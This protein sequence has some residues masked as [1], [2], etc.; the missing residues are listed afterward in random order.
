MSTI[1]LLRAPLLR[2][3]DTDGLFRANVSTLPQ[4]TLMEL[5][6][7]DLNFKNDFYDAE[8]D[9]RPVS[10]WTGVNTKEHNITS[11]YWF[12]KSGRGTMDLQF[13][14]RTMTGLHVEKSEITGS[15]DLSNLPQQMERLKLTRNNFS[16]SIDLC[17]LPD[18]F[19]E[20]Y[21]NYNALSGSLNLTKLPQSLQMA[22][23]DS[24]KFSGSIN[25][26]KL[27]EALIA[28][29]ADD[30]SLSGTLDLDNLP[31]NIDE[32]T[33]NGNRISGTIN[34]TALPASLDMLDVGSNVVTRVIGVEY[35]CKNFS[36]YLQDNVIEQDTVRA[37]DSVRIIALRGNT[38]GKIVDAHGKEVA[39]E[40]I[41]LGKVDSDLE[42]D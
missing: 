6:V 7:A 20:L 33:L 11:I 28:L 35:L 13:L 16:D 37:N 42:E 3:T 18:G 2:L 40:K 26:T 39:C 30:N 1:Y 5:L 29:F 23:F 22:N 8:G 27:P 21:I 15:L 24:N 9:F 14:P 10:D 38:I 32:I 25:L 36:L 41:T 12:Q 31:P 19:R 34:V 4:H 17:H